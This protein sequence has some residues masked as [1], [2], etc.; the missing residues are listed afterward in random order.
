MFLKLLASIFGTAGAYV[1][2]GIVWAVYHEFT[3]PFRLLPGPKSAHWFYG[4]AKELLDDVRGFC[5]MIPI[6][7]KSPFLCL[8]YHGLQERWVQEYGRTWKFHRFFVSHL[9]LTRLCSDE[10][11]ARQGQTG[12]YTTDLK[13]IHHFLSNSQIYQKS[14]DTRF[15]LGRVVGPGILVVEGDV[16][17]QQVCYVVF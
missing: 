16:H 10:L 11:C 5:W 8:K 7:I 15:S 1:L 14:E 2:Y 12:M 6:L 13:A 9:I 3:S 17:K 4:N